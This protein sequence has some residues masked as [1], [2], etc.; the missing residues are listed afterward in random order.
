MS[1]E[2]AKEMINALQQNEALRNQIE[3]S[4]S[5]AEAAFNLTVELGKQQGLN[6]TAEEFQRELEARGL[7]VNTDGEL[8]SLSTTVGEEG[9]ISEEAL[10][11]VA[12]GFYYG[13]SRGSSC[14]QW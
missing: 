13:N 3:S 8:E 10:E 11:A 4:S 12:G 2:N 7:G 1:A 14:S 6:F 9:E 5:S